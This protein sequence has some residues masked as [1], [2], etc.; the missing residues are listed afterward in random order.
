VKENQYDADRNISRLVEVWVSQAAARQRRGRAGRT[1]PGTCYKLYTRQQEEK[2]AKFP[3]PEISRVPLESVLL[4][5][6]STKEEEDAKVGELYLCSP[7]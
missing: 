3:I 7:N 2:L 1:K 5:I 4:S 6:K